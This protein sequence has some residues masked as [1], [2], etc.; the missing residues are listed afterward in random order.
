MRFELGM[1]KR[2]GASCTT[3]GLRRGDFL[4]LVDGR[5]IADVI[6][7][8]LCLVVRWCV[9]GAIWTIVGALGFVVVVTSGAGP[10]I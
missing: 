7:G 1:S 6:P 9:R 2:V 4:A 5:S 3:A 8:M 10:N